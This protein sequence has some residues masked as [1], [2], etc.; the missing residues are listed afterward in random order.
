VGAPFDPEI[1]EA[2]ATEPSDAHDENTVIQEWCGGYRLHGRL[3]RAAK[4]VLA[5]PE[6]SDEVPLETDEAPVDTHPASA[7]PEPEAIDET[8][9]LAD[10]AAPAPAEADEE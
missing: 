10:D 8:P 2:I 9:V 3:L 5:A 7:E 1:H 4:V 6:P